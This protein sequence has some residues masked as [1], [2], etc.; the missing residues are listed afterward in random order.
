MCAVIK[1]F[2][3]RQ[4]HSSFLQS[5]GIWFARSYREISER[6]WLDMLS[7]SSCSSL[8]S[9]ISESLFST[10]LWFKVLLAIFSCDE[11]ASCMSSF[12]CE[13]FSDCRVDRFHYSLNRTLWFHWIF[14][15]WSSASGIPH[16][17]GLPQPP[18]KSY[19]LGVELAV[20]YL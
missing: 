1:I 11:F 8:C 2:T 14:L 4:V 9:M 16:R 15:A 12:G 19:H 5:R 7:I 18:I 10:V 20:C 6:F 3:W 17:Q 13:T